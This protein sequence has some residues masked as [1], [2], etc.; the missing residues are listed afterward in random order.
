MKIETWFLVSSTII[1][2]DVHICILDQ[3][4]C[5]CYSG[6]LL[7]KTRWTNLYPR[8]RYWLFWNF[9]HVVQ[10]STIRLVLCQTAVRK[11]DCTTWCKKHSCSVF[12]LKTFIWFKHMV[13][14]IKRYMTMCESKQNH[15]RAY[16]RTESLI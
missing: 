11:L 15:I 16:A 13:S 6:M 5:E 12:S 7:V 4:I 9:I 10:H 3:K 2:W 14:L 8:P 1:Y